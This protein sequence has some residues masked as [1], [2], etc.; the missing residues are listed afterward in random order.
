M[1]NDDSDGKDNTSLLL[2]CLLAGQNTGKIF[3]LACVCLSSCPASLC[4]CVCVWLS[5]LTSWLAAALAAGS[6]SGC[7]PAAAAAAAATAAAAA[8]A[9]LPELRAAVLPLRFSNVTQPHTAPTMM[10]NRRAP[11]TATKPSWLGLK[12]LA[13]RQPE[14]ATALVH[15]SQLESLAKRHSDNAK[16]CARL[17]LAAPKRAEPAAARLVIP[18]PGRDFSGL[19]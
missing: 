7:E 11:H 17:P 6:Q 14:L 8:A 12:P 16:L 5:G 1:G 4:W 13:A 18:V 10:H 3:L 9:S 2:S 19:L 15:C